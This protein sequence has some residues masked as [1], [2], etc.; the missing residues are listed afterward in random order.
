MGA[1]VID[2]RSDLVT[3]PT[4]RMVDEMVKAAA[5]KCSYGVREDPIQRH[6]EELASEVLGKEDALFC[7]TTTMCNQIAINIICSPGDKVIAESK[8][9]CI[10]S[11]GGAPAVLSGVLAEPV[12]GELGFMNLQQL[13][14]AI[15][16]GDELNSR[17]SL[18][19][20]ENTHNR[21]GGIAISVPQMKQIFDIAKRHNILVHLDGARLF[22]AA[23]YFK[24]P[25]SD[26]SKYTDTVAVSL[27]KGLCA[28][29]GCI[30]AGSKAF[31][32]E[33]VLVRH[34]FGG[35]W[36]PTGILAAA[37]IVA[38][39][40]MID[41]LADDHRN[42]RRV[43]E[44]ITRCKGI[45]VDLDKVQTNIVIV[46][47]N[48]SKFGLDE[49]LERLKSRKILVLKRGPDQIRLV[50]HKEIGGDES[51]EIIRSFHEIMD[52]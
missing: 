51:D 6:L 40:T 45:F 19:V 3:R 13:E 32:K 39:E 38:L 31:I 26:L 46:K 8:S 34:R 18:I 2:L 49:F 20:V 10:L 27:N 52:N 47:V 29:M 43:A 22:N 15:H 14:Q 11:E 41:R 42:A 12:H 23:V 5:S 1:E 21:S 9:H 25:V 36:R 4:P 35:G 7:P 24:V 30:L 37:G 28:P 17:T 33:A 50:F 16:P 48:H 44:A